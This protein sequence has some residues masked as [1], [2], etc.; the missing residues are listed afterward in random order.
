ME[1]CSVNNFHSNML[2]H[3]DA[4]CLGISICF[5]DKVV[6]IL[7]FFWLQMGHDI[8]E[9]RY[10]LGLA[11]HVSQGHL[12]FHVKLYNKLLATLIFQSETEVKEREGRWDI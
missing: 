10:E 6:F 2:S 12:V 4:E 3:S 5:S 7:T 1:G 9:L 8:K 11:V